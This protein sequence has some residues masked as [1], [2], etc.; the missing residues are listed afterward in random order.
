MADTITGVS[1]AEV[2]VMESDPHTV[3]WVYPERFATTL[4]VTL[5]RACG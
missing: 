5:R 2:C 3:L 4:E 1:V